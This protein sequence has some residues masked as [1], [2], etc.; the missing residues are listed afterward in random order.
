MGKVNENSKKGIF[1][2][3]SLNLSSVLGDFKQGKGKGKGG[4][5]N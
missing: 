2:F 1:R 3:S 5:G 4:I